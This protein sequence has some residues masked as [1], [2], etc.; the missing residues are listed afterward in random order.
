VHC[1]T[2]T[3]A[4]LAVPPRLSQRLRVGFS[5]Q[6]HCTRCHD[7]GG[8]PGAGYAIIRQDNLHPAAR[9]AIRRRRARGVLSVSRSLCR[10]VGAY[11]SSS[12][13]LLRQIVRRARRFCQRRRLPVQALTPT[14]LPQGEGLKNH[15]SIFHPLAPWE[16]GL[17]GEGYTSAVSNLKRLPCYPCPYSP[18]RLPSVSVIHAM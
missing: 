4:K 13:P 9:R 5:H 11:L 15:T 14:P 10:R 16:R 2:G 1:C 8:N 3:S 12:Q 6:V 7:N 17:G 18:T